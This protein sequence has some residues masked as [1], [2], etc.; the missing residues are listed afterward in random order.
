MTFLEIVGIVTLCYL[1]IGLMFV[2]VVVASDFDNF[3]EDFV[4]EIRDSD[5]SSVQVLL[6]SIICWPM[7]VFLEL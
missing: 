1:A 7:L 6:L 4:A 5:F 3:R 2:I